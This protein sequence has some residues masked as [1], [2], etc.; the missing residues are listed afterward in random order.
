VISQHSNI[1]FDSA[2]P[3]VGIVFLDPQQVIYV[4]DGP[5]PFGTNKS[6]RLS[7]C[8]RIPSSNRTLGLCSVRSTTRRSAFSQ[9]LT[10]VE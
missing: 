7:A 5:S 4:K 10:I 3:K 8:I 9:S 1:V 2:R 6:Y